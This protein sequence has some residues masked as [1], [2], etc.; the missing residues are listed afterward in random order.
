M[1][2]GRLIVAFSDGRLEAL[3][4]SKMP[5][6][7]VVE[8]AAGN[9]LPDPVLFELP[10]NCFA[11]S[12]KKGVI[13]IY[14]SLTLKRIKSIAGD[15]PVRSIIPISKGRIC[16]LFH[17]GSIGI[18][19][20][21]DCSIQK[22]EGAKLKG[23]YNSIETDELIREISGDRIALIANRVDSSGT[24]ND[25]IEVR[26]IGGTRTEFLLS[27]KGI[28]KEIVSFTSLSDGR[29]L[30]GM[31]NGGIFVCDPDEREAH[32][33]VYGHKQMVLGL[34]P[35]S[36]DR[37][38]SASVNGVVKI[39]N[40]KTWTCEQKFEMQSLVRRLIR[41]SDISAAVV[42]DNKISIIG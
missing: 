20:C 15:E 1:P 17:S 21:N 6:N 13:Y 4:L 8:K 26:K 25:A 40:T 36:G 37:L 7:T 18:A 41:L 28:I 14:S 35:L 10:N 19:R 3:D 29:L 24:Y 9:V 27:D 2:D 38:I 39:W 16:V 33:F 42:E 12:V 30:A 22:I 5:S 23:G 31:K 32:K 11:Y 34:V